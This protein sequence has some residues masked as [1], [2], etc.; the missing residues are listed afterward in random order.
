MKRMGRVRA[1]APEV[2]S[3][4][5]SARSDRRCLVHEGQ[6]GLGGLVHG[7]VDDGVV[8]LPLGGQLHAGGRQAPLD[9]LGGLRAPTLQPLHED[10]PGRRRQEDANRF[11][12]AV[13]DL[14]GA[15]EFDLQEYVVASGKGLLDGLGRRAI[16]V[17]GELGP[18][19]E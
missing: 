4:P 7:G 11:G 16:E 13:A 2:K 1:V 19:E 10:L 18:L 12:G 15:L 5:R 17:S 8:E 6:D 14:A 9:H 3:T